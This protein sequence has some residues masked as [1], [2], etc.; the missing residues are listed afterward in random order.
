[1]I[2]SIYIGS[3][4][5]DLFSDE[6]IEVVSSIADSSD[7]TANNTDYSKSFTVPASDTNNAIFKH[8]YDADINNTFDARVKVDG[9]IELD[10]LPF[11]SGKFVLDKVNLKSGKA[12][13]YAIN[14]F[15]KLVSLKDKVKED[16]LSVLD[17][18]DFTHTYNSN[19]VLN[20]LVN[21]LFDKSIVYN[22]LSKRRYYYSS[23][24]T[25][26]TNTETIA[27]IAT[28]GARWNDL[29]PSIKLIRIIEAIENR[30]DVSF[31]RDFFGRA[32]FDNLYLWL[33]NKLEGTQ[34]TEQLI[35]FN[36]GSSEGFNLATDTWVNI[37][38]L[39]ATKSWKIIVTPIGESITTPYTIV[40]KNNGVVVNRIDATGFYE[41]AFVPVPYDA[42][43][44]QPFSYQFF[45]AS[46]ESMTYKADLLL[47]RSGVFGY[48]LIQAL[49]E[50]NLS[51]LFYVSDNMPKIKIIDFLKSISQMFKLVVI[52]NNSNDIYINSLVDY[53]SQ[54]RLYDVTEYIDFESSTVARGKLFNEI[55]FLFESPTT[56]LNM[57]FK[58]NTTLGYG[59]EK[60]KLTDEDGEPLDGGKFEVKIPFEQ[61]IYER[62]TDNNDGLSTNIMY[63]LIADKELKPVNPK[64]HVF[65]N[66]VVSMGSK[67]FK[68]STSFGGLS[69]INGTVNTASHTFTFDNP[70]YSTIFSEEFNEWDGSIISNTLYSNY[71]K[72]YIESVFNIKR[73]NYKFNGYL[74]LRLLLSLKLNDIL[75]INENYF[76]IDNFTLNL[77]T[78]ETELNLINSF[79]NTINPFSVDSTVIFSDARQ[80]MQTIYVK[81]YDS[82]TVEI[83]DI[84]SGTS[85]SSYTINDRL[86]TINLDENLT[87]LQRSINVKI[88]NGGKEIDVEIIQ[89]AGVV[90][91][92]NN[93]ITFDS[94][95]ITF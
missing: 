79:D 58:E 91:F 70:Q 21:G 82:F 72:D 44:P 35:D 81:G 14:F 7:I 49:T 23:D 52:Q 84:G 47:R 89:Q 31:S 55:N 85:W 24:A 30:Y 37:S 9:R 78:Q 41:G 88:V 36:S 80:P 32:E 12:S 43:D 34:Q 26:T 48:D 3:D 4:K 20:G 8:Y 39:A 67:P 22:M 62:L 33:N 94:T 74:P 50:M 87:G 27:N 75:K 51:A 13:S 68:L 15:G 95:L 53:Y 66:N 25:D 69:V 65:Y 5:L 38:S 93:V 42:T 71:Y 1:M 63:G 90:S 40:V 16:E 73:R 60:T 19:N 28:A 29:K 83:E 64:S 86:I 57:Q 76:R 11:K 77:T 6:N 2:V 59:D 54:G 56:L 46:N 45:I 10:G 18:T 17:L 61:F 92:D